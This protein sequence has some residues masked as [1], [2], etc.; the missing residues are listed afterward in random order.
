M[1]QSDCT[2][3]IKKA[4]NMDEENSE[5]DIPTSI[6][7]PMRSDDKDKRFFDDCGYM[8]DKHFEEIK[9]NWQPQF[10][11]FDFNLYQATMEF[12]ENKIKD[13]PNCVSLKQQLMLAGFNKNTSAKIQECC[14]R[15]E[16]FDWEP[17]IYCCLLYTSPSPRDS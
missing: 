7:Q 15:N 14:E 1:N 8:I 10:P 12:I 13:N 6:K 2:P 11:S 17:L 9:G 4:R 3:P 5:E 16:V